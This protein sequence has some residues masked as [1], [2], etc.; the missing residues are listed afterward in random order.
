MQR[1]FYRRRRFW[2]ELVVLAGSFAALAAFAAQSDRPGIRVSMRTE[3]IEAVLGK[4]DLQ[5]NI[6]R[7]PNLDEEGEEDDPEPFV[8][9]Y[10]QPGNVRVGFNR[11]GKAVSVKLPPRPPLWRRLWDAA[12]PKAGR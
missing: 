7:W 5:V 1:L 9:K 4:A 2:A 3:Q 11:R 6:D 8:H 12:G 10:W